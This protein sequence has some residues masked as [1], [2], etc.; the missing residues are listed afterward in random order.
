[1]AADLLL[2]LEL[3]PFHADDD[4]LPR[5][6]LRLVPDES[7]GSL[8]LQDVALDRGDHAGSRRIRWKFQCSVLERLRPQSLV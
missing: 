3:V 6:D 5:L 7:L 2:L 4:A 8:A 1:L